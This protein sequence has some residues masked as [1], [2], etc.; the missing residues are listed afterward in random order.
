MSTAI[1]KGGDDDGAVAG[2]EVEKRFSGTRGLMVV[3]RKL[4]DS[5]LA[6]AGSWAQPG[7]A[8]YVRIRQAGDKG[9]AVIEKEEESR[10]ASDKHE[11]DL[12]R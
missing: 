8:V 6:V 9:Y 4:A 1:L 10:E 5:A 11:A 7:V 12:F 3:V 2:P